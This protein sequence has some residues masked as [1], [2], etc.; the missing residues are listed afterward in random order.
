MNRSKFMPTLITDTCEAFKQSLTSFVEKGGFDNENLSPV[1]IVEKFVRGLEEAS[2]EACRSGLVDLIESYEIEE[3]N[4]TRDDKHYHLKARTHKKFLSRFGEI[5]VK[6]KTF[7]HWDGGPGIVPLDEIMAMTGRYV[8]ADV[9]EFILYGSGMLKPT[10]LQGMFEKTNHFRPSAS[11]IRDIINQD[12]QAFDNFLHDENK[13]TSVR[14]IK[15]PETPVKALVASFDGANV[16]VREPGK[17]RGARV[18]KP[19]KEGVKN[20][21][22]EKSC[23]YKNAMVGSISFYDVAEVIDFETQETRLQ[24]DRIKSSYIGRMP[25]ERYPKFKAEFEQA[26]SQAEEVAPDDIV[27]ILLMDGARGFWAYADESPIYD[28]YIKVVD[29]YHAAE[30]LSRLAE[31]LFGKSSKTGQQW[32]E[33]WLSK[34][35]HDANGVASMLRSAGRY[36]KERKLSRNKT[37]DLNTELTFFNRN[38]DRMDYASLVQQGLP[39]GS[40]PV[41]A[42]C[43]MIVKNRFCQSGMRWSIQGGQ[44]VMNIRVVQKSDQWEDTWKQFKESGGYKNYQQQAA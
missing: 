30:H 14:E 38:K 39:I 44:N 19:S 3:D 23:S 40:G 5:V 8:M 9:V 36:A 22:I 27:K 24:P 7:H 29:F 12:G 1:Q 37:K 13:P 43:K 2:G 16:L 42:A 41:E 11:L 18:K 15:A 26:L 21:P 4:L 33:K 34:I 25:E 10:E 35:K 17:K 20:E 32:Y 6:R 28:D 31:A